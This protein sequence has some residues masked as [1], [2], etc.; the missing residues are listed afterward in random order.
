MNKVKIITDST[1]DL[2]KDLANKY[3]VEVIPLFVTFDEESYRDG[4]DIT[5]EELYEIIE[6]KK[7]L[8]KTAAIDMV[9][10]TERFKYW[11]DL[12]Y[13]VIFSGISKQMSRTYENAIMAKDEL[14]E[15]G[16]RIFI[17]DSMNLST[18][19]GLTILKACKMRDEGLGAKEIAT[20]MEEIVTRVKAQFGIE[21]M[22]YLHKGGRCSGVARFVGTLLKIKPIIF[23]REGKMSVGMKPI[24]KMKVALDKMIN[25]FLEDYKNGNVD[26]DNVFITHSIAYESEKYIREKLEAEVKAMNIISTVA[27][28]VIS[29]HCGKGT[30]GILYITKNK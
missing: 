4:E 12:G 22:E 23:V 24:G 15:Y 9:T 27:G 28:G 21:T 16:D 3:D 17:V 30:I 1:C 10:I 26:L 7:K 18:G 14:S 13:D 19:I 25:M 29:S 8:P 5:T 2:G 20:K 11:L 6:K